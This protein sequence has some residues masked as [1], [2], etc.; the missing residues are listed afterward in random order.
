MSASDPRVAIY[1][2]GLLPTS[3]TFI[4][5]QAL[6]L[7]RWKPVLLG[8]YRIEKGLDLSGLGFEIIPEAGG[9]AGRALRFGPQWPEPRLLRRLKELDVQLVHAH[10]GTDATDI[11]PTVRAAGLPML[12]TLHGYDINTH[13]SWWES[14]KG[15]LFRR[16][17]PK[18]LLSM[19]QDS[20]VRFIAVSDAI[21]RQAVALGIAP[22]K[23]DLSFI[24]VDTECFKP[25]GI[26]LAARDPHIL[27]VGRMVEKKNPLLLVQAF[28][29][30]LSQLPNAELTMIGDGPLL[31]EAKLLATR[32]GVSVNFPGE[33]TGEA[34]RN[35][36]RMSRVI[37]LPSKVATN[38][39]SEGLPIVLLEAQAC[40]VPVIAT[41]NGGSAECIVN[42]TT[43]LVV[44]EDD[45]QALVY[46]LIKALTDAN[47][48]RDTPKA[49]V[50][51]IVKNFSLH[52]RSA[53][54]ESLY[55]SAI[56]K[57]PIK[58]N[59]QDRYQ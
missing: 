1:T 12:V 58:P 49:C 30:L 36:M 31:A 41:P 42:G 52:R 32:L 20:N 25:S 44:P 9:R 56:I 21:K 47:F 51:H 57:D 40:G 24:G 29:D 43:G 3:Q 37:C 6:A 8:R 54:L 19:A 46:A 33:L 59:G 39:D 34:V 7:T 55:D 27:F 5:S 50:S 2:R 23:I 17:Y 18:R 14:G 38:G 26:S 16:W 28:A 22:G 45:R 4:R 48:I 11:W 15:G 13:R 53:V 10:F 35:H